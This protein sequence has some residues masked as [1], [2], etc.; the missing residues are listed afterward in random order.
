MSLFKDLFGFPLFGSS[1]SEKEFPNFKEIDFLTKEKVDE[2]ELKTFN[3]IYKID[4][5]EYES[6]K[7]L[8][9]NGWSYSSHHVFFELGIKLKIM[10]K[11]SIRD[12]LLLEY[13]ADIGCSFIVMDGDAR[14]LKWRRERAELTQQI[15]EVIKE[16][17]RKSEVVI[18]YLEMLD[19][20]SR[21][22]EEKKKKEYEAEMVSCYLGF[23]SCWEGKDAG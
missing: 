16:A 19:E 11:D 1:E 3:I 21:K 13:D 2:L 4:F 17:Q 10:K 5:R 22:E 8:K 9:Q 7:F 18:S 6:E 15:K 20:K 12:E 23:K 14:T